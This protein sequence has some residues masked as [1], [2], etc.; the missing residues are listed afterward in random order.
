M[1]QPAPILLIEDDP[2]AIRTFQLAISVL[3]VSAPVHCL[4][5]PQEALGFLKNTNTVPGLILCNKPLTAINGIDLREAL[6]NDPRLH[7]MAI[8]IVLLSSGVSE[9]VMEKTFEL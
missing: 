8:P 6:A 1:T 7:R 9:A 3:N 4:T 5:S 2:D